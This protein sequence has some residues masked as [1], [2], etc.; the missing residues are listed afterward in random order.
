MKAFL[1]LATTLLSSCVTPDHWSAESH[2]DMMAQCRIMC[3]DGCVHSYD[4][5]TGQCK[6]TDECREER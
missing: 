3:G 6:C 1:L 4:P 5:W 2:R